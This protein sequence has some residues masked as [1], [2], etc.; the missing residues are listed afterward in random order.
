MSILPGYDPW[1]GIEGTGLRFDPEAA[2]LALEFFP[3]MLTHVEGQ[4]ARTPFY[5][6]PWQKAFVGNLFGWMRAD[7]SRRYREGMLYVPRKN[8]KTVLVAGVCL[9][10]LVCDGER[11]AQIYSAAAEKEQAALLFRQ[12]AGMVAN[13]PELDSEQGGIINVFGGMTRRSLVYEA[14]GSAYRALSSDAKTK[15][16]LTPSLAIVDEEH[17]LRDREL[18][19]TLATGMASKN[20]KNPLFLHVTTADYD[21][22]S[23]C[24]EKHK[25]ASEV[26]DGTVNDLYF[27]PAIFEATKDDDW[28]DERTWEK[29]NPNLDISVSRDYLRAEIEKA[30][31]NPELENG[32]RR[33][34]LNQKTATSVIWMPL[35]MWDESSGLEGGETPE[36]WRARKIEELRNR[37]CVLGV[38]LSGSEDLTAV[39]ALFPAG[40]EEPWTALPWFWCPGINA[41][42]RSKKD[43][44]PYETWERQGW[45]AF[46][47][48]TWVDQ[49]IIKM[50]IIELCETFDVREISYDPWNAEGTAADL[51]VRGFPAVRCP[52]VAS[53]LS[54]PMKFC[55]GLAT[56][57]LLHHGGHPVLRWNIG[58]TQ[59]IKDTNGNIRPDKS[60]KTERIDGVSAMVTGM[61]GA[62]RLDFSGEQW[63]YEKNGLPGL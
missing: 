5:L 2:R 25:Y 47:E 49:H 51:V 56:G 20:R 59:A 61:A 21:K 10:V 27:L 12:A 16:G 58:N 42:K 41:R 38:D 54:E 15:H 34:H 17:A 7:G 45:L 36:A 50:K 46:T 29:S 32:F 57:G 22:P 53:R 11:G 13:N 1:R 23:I 24:N 26:R 28:T 43:H 14:N 19:D 3:E 62:I 48:G 4:L 18:V 60:A 55:F 35:P 31:V 37:P 30:K 40:P 33:L 44:V 6:E 63:D 52:Q 8:G 39:V 9:F